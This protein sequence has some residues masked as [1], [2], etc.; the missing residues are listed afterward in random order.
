MNNYHYNYSIKIC[1]AVKDKESIFG[2]LPKCLKG[3]L[4]IMGPCCISR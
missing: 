3:K 2:L 1:Y 4:I